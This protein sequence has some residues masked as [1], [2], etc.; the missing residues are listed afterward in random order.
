MDAGVHLPLIDFGGQ[1][2]SYR[3][4]ADTVDAASACGFDSI[5]AN[6]HFLFAAPWFDGLTALAAVAGRSGRMRLVTTLALAAL[7]GPVPVAKSLAALDLLCDGRLIAGLG[8]GS[9]R[10]DYEAVGLP[11]D[12]RWQRL[13]EAAL[14]I[15]KLLQPATEADAAPTLLPAPRQSRVP[16]WIGS[17]GSRAGLRRVARLGDGWL[18][19]AYNTT[20]EGFGT[21]MGFLRAELERQGRPPGDLGNALV[22]MWTW[23]T[24]SRSDADRV[25]AD[26]VSPMI[27]RDPAELRGRICVGTA[28]ECAELLSQYAEA[29]CQR[30]H[31]WPVGDEVRQIELI[32][33]D[34]MPRV[35]R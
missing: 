23:V 14:L 6:D 7:R 31:F 34:V 16:I 19:S 8:P 26:V 3:R 9:S 11:F 17:W 21:S 33:G 24:D 10:A 1:G 13:D 18:A 12:E 2:F 5:S 4:L 35:S 20:P 25:I 27:K 22:T 32:T 15:R 30:V 28:A 29:G